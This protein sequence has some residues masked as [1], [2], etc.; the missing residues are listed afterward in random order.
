MPT[1]KVFISHASA[2]L[3]V[4]VH[5]SDLL[6][7]AGIN[8][9]LDQQDL[10]RGSDFVEFMNSAVGASDFCL[11][12]WS[13]SAM[14]SAWVNEE[15]H[16]AYTRTVTENRAFLVVGRLQ[17]IKVPHLLRSRLWVDLFPSI[18]CGIGTLIR[19]WQADRAVATA[20]GYSVQ[21]SA[22]SFDETEGELLYVSS[23]LYDF[24]C[25]IRAPLD[26]PAGLLIDR[27]IRTSGLKKRIKAHDRIALGLDYRLMFRG[28]E[29]SRS[30]SLRTAGITRNAALHLV[31]Y[32]RVIAATLPVSGRTEYLRFL[33]DPLQPTR[34]QVVVSSELLNEIRRDTHF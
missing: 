17:D 2:D 32:A 26:Q 23:D 13:E 15:W 28:R 10:G 7:A 22:R 20:S 19:E 4:A 9:M 6:K 29:L 33:A 25:P 18:E 1:P 8:T 5:A 30:D 14:R 21:P 16:A 11:L 3:P 27:I 34:P 31:V 12:L 24:T